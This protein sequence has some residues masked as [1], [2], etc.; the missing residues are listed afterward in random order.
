MVG[1]SEFR[2]A[3]RGRRPV[4]LLADDER[5]HAVGRRSGRGVADAVERTVEHPD[6]AL[7]AKHGALRDRWRRSLLLAQ[8]QPRRLRG[9]ARGRRRPRRRRGAPSSTRRGLQ[10][11]GRRLDRRARRRHR[12]VALSQL[13]GLQGDRRRARREPHHEG[14]ADGMVRVEPTDTSPLSDLF[15]AAGKVI[16]LSTTPTTHSKANAVFTKVS[17]GL[18]TVSRRLGATRPRLRCGPG[19]S[20]TTRSRR[21]SSRRQSFGGI[22]VVSTTQYYHTTTMVRRDTAEM[23]RQNFGSCFV[24]SNVAL[25]RAVSSVKIPTTNIGVELSTGHVPPRLVA[26]RRSGVDA[27]GRA[28]QSAPRDGGDH[29]RTLRSDA[30]RARQ[31]SGRSPRRSSRASR[32]RLLSRIVSPSSK[33]V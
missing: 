28:R 32:A 18:S 15:S 9:A 13:V 33:P 26:R 10:R 20:P 1:S 17:D 4:T 14:P 24:T 11:R 31:R 22:E 8:P 2:A 16:T 23:S 5:P 3:R 21:R 19:S 7:R 29:R 6:R 27:A 25:V 30:R 12:L